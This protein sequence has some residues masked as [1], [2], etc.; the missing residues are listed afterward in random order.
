MDAARLNFSHGSHDEHAELARLVRQAQRESGR[1]L[2][3][4]ADLQGPKLR[5]G[6]LAGPVTL[7]VGD[8]IFVGGENGAHDGV[9][10]VSPSVI[11]DVLRPGHDVVIDDGRVWL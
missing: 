1:P 5:I 7:A 9:L 3:L 6:E 10:P 11:G 4:V 8:E 2:A